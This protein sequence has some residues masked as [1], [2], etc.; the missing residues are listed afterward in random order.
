M[1]KLL[2]VVGATGQQG[3]SVVDSILGDAQ[4]RKEYKI[5][6]TTR[7]PGS[8]KGRALAK[9]GVEVVAADVN[10]EGSLR[11]AFAGAYAVFASMYL[12]PEPSG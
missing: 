8:D 10:D 2:V 7:D 12:L 9:K 6:G 1:S 4:L 3:G 5:R 11:K